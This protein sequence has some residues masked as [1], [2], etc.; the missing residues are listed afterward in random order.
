MRIG[1]G[2]GIDFNWVGGGIRIS[3]MGFCE[4]VGLNGMEEV[5]SRYRSCFGFVLVGIS[6]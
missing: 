4:G 1:I 2:L 6:I 3:Y 5:Y